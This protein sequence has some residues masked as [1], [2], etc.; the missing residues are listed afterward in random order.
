MTCCSP[1]IL[2]HYDDPSLVDLYFVDP[3]WLCSILACV[4]TVQERNPFQKN[5][6]GMRPCYKHTPSTVDELKIS[7][8]HMYTYQGMLELRCSFNI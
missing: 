2:L 3:Q 8:T 4:V 5:G 7:H 6:K 1:G